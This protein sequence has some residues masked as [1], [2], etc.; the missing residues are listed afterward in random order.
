MTT[1]AENETLTQV[2]AG[3]PMG[4]L[5]R[6][7]WLPAAK[8]DELAADGDPMR[9]M[10]LG[11]KLIAFRDSS[12][13]VGVMDHRCPHRCASF[14]F[15]RNEED[16]IRCVYHGWKFDVHGNCLDMA[17]VPPHQDF[18]HKVKAKTYKAEER[19]GLIWVFMGDQDNVPEL[20]EIEATLIPDAE[21]EIGFHQREC[22]WLQAIEGEID[23][24][25]VGLLHYGNLDSST[26]P[27]DGI[28][29]YSVANRA[30]E[31][32]TEETDY[33]F[34]YGAHRPAD[35]GNLYWRVAH[36]M[37]PF[38]ALPPVNVIES[39]FMARAYVPMDDTHTMILVMVIKND[40]YGREVRAIPG[41]SMDLEYEP[42]S[43]DWYGRWRLTANAG[44]DYMIDR[45]VQREETYTGIHGIVVQDHAINE[46]MGPIVDRTFE[47]LAP[48]DMMINRVRR[49]LIK[50]ARIHAK[51]GT[52]PVSA[53]D[54]HVYHGIRSGQY[55]A[56]AE[57]NWLDAY[58][59]IIADNPV[60]YPLPDA[61]E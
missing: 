8:S 4:D 6:Q 37:F 16:G 55:V 12:G 21:M 61:A 5:M 10:L 7:Y 51:D 48:S 20:P 15:G 33:G 38:W 32:I 29:K 53:S 3:T 60:R 42:N 46:G 43:T 49:M 25:H 11:E 30:P 13:R 34:M 47:Q 58:A 40:P 2:G 41:G 39:N 45:D 52:A 35:E 14:F 26:F 17:N 56:P 28:R 18:K 36:L 50:A 31:Y 44:N 57:L 59:K 24:S 27:K 1:N 22:N 19:N 23:T 54:P 9:L